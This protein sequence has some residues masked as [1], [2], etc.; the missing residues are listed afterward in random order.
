MAT[1]TVVLRR[2]SPPGAFP[3]LA[4]IDGG[5]FARRQRWSRETL[6][7]T[8]G[9][10]P[11]DRTAVREFLEA[12]GLH[13]ES[14]DLA[15]RSIQAT[16]TLEALARAFRTKLETYSGPG[17]T[18]RGREGPLHVPAP[19]R[20]IVVGVFGLDNRPQ[21]VPHFRPRPP[22]ARADPSYTPLEV[23]AA[24]SFPTGLNGAGEG[25][26][27]IELGGGFRPQDLSAYFA[28][29]G[30]PAP[31]VTTV[32]VDGAT[33]APTGSAN[34]PDGEV[35]L[36]LEV[37]GAIAPG[38]RLVAYFAPNTDQGFL[39][40]VST[41]VHDTANHLSI[42]SISWGGP[43]PTWT[44]QARAA[45]EAVFEEAAALGVT[46]LVA[47]GD[48]G[49]TDGVASGAL[50]V[51]Y[52]ASSPGVVGCGGTHLTITGGV[53]TA[54]TVWN[55]LA[56]GEGAT[57]GGV[58][59]LF[60]IPAYQ[61]SAGVP[62]APN[63]FAGRGVPDVAGDADPVTGYS[64]V[65]DGQRTVIGGTSAVAPLWAGLVAR[66]NQS[67]GSPA[68]YVNAALYRLLGTPAFR[69]ITSGD[70]GGY[71]AGPGWNACDGLGSPVGSALLQALRTA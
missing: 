67:L 3:S 35:E 17:G 68:G 61:A 58:S 25:I 53:D 36:D 55:E 45:F 21:A 1:I 62:V 7:A 29:L 12:A 18:Y 60:P 50:T 10:R 51:D 26:G 23:A 48:N 42:V 52:P 13:I 34:G 43:E 49:A 59:E 57:G 22:R 14:D 11:E 20:E 8:H 33:N 39:D 44:V 27:L 9:A 32:S 65:V 19:L 41:A 28:S 56:R 5:S 24:Y 37:A 46:V 16:G 31:S 38:A 6:A 40:A 4:E 2:R 47:A 66:I 30:V 54:E 15:R 70:N 63:G 69:E 71:T 64:V